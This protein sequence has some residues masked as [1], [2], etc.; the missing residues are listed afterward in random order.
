[1]VKNKKLKLKDLN[2]RS[3][4]TSLDGKAQKAV[5][6]GTVADPIADP[7]GAYSLPPYCPSGVGECPT[8]LELCPSYEGACE[9]EATNCYGVCFTLEYPCKYN[10]FDILKIN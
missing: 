7:V 8:C 9:S 10:I 4:V 1:M 5:K 2:V 3:F 6:G